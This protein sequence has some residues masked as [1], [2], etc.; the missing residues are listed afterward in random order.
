MKDLKIARN[1]SFK[2]INHNTIHVLNYQNS[3]QAQGTA[4]SLSQYDSKT[5]FTAKASYLFYSSF[6]NNSQ[7]LT[8]SDNGGWGTSSSQYSTTTSTPD[9]S[10]SLVLSSNGYGYGALNYPN[11]NSLLSLIWSNSIMIPMIRS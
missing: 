3:S 4:I 11:G 1:G 10:S 5:D 7:V 6:T 8:S 9:G 2:L